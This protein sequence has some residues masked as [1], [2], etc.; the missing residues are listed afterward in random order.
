MLPVNS[1]RGKGV[2]MVS[3]NV[4][5]LGHPIK[6]AKVFT[7]LKSLSS[8]LVFLQETYIR[9]SEQSRLRCNW[10]G[11]IFQSTFSSKAHGVAIIIKKN[12]PFHHINTI[13]DDSG[14]FLIVTGQLYSI[15]VTLVNI[16]GPNVD[17]VG[18]F[19]KIFG[20]LPDLS[21]TNLIIA[22]DFNAILDWHL[23]RSS[24]KQSSPSNASVTLNSLISSTNI[25]D[26]WCLQHPT[27]R[28]YS[29]FSKLHNSYSRIDFFLLD[30]KL[31]YHNTVISDHAP[32]SVNLDFNQQKQHTTWRLRPYLINDA[33]FCKYL[34]GK[35]DEFLDTNDTSDTS[36]SN[37][38]ETFKVVMRGHTIS[39]E[40]SLKKSRSSRLV[41][42]DSKLSQLE[43]QYK[44]SNNNQTLQEII[45]LKYEYNTILTKQVSDQLSRLRTRYFELGDKPHTLLARQ[46]RGQQNSRAILRIR[47]GTGDILT[48][49]KSINKRFVKFY[50][51]LYKAKAKGK[52]DNLLANS[53]RFPTVYD[54]K[55]SG[56][57]VH[58]QTPSVTGV[59]PVRKIVEPYIITH[60]AFWYTVGS[61]S[62]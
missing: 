47:S 53:Q 30:S 40:A 26:I 41:E 48:N 38:W 35:F 24:K 25:V 7:H 45:N 15:H 10:A 34:S 2:T 1:S 52:V 60:S 29:F 8:D 36:D 16:Y 54:T 61:S 49:P 13:S 19:R 17:D 22:G 62:T 43:T 58:K 28:E 37:L 31:L 55:L 57:V 21:N 6:R 4:K 59:R 18:F 20:K 39:Y 46:L 27:D 33:D 9:P 14:R 44:Q 5:G 42:I 23:D 50:Q 12:I 56:L 51:E 11:H 32:V 3:W